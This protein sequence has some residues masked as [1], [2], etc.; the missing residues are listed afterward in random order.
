M[1]SISS[2]EHEHIKF[3]Y[4]CLYVC[5]GEKKIKCGIEI[6][7]YIYCTF[8]L[9]GLQQD[10]PAALHRESR[11]LNLPLPQVPKYFY[12]IFLSNVP[13]LPAIL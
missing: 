9:L 12:F 5:K 6:V 1:N 8:V 13:I 2:S 10:V 7:T 4:V 11:N 3:I